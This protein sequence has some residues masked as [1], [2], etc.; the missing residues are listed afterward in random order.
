MH[1]NPALIS[2]M[3][4]AI[5][6]KILSVYSDLYSWLALWGDVEVIISQLQTSKREITL[7]DVIYVWPPKATQD[8]LILLLF[9]VQTFIISLEQPKT[10]NCEN[11]IQPLTINP[12]SLE[13]VEIVH[14]PEN[15]KRFNLRLYYKNVPTYNGNYNFFPVFL[16]K[17]V[18][19]CKKVWFLKVS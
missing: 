9:F 7:G 2:L 13:Y 1:F 19:D 3:Y 4:F 5:L 17:I 14:Q 15:P 8:F 11:N 6:F 12:L 16:G 10:K 18:Y